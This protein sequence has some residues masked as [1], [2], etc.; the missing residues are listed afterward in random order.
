MPPKIDLAGKRFGRLVVIKEVDPYYP[1]NSNKRHRKWLCKCDC[2]NY[3][4]TYQGGLLRG[5]TKSCSCLRKENIKQHTNKYSTNHPLYKVLLSMRQRCSNPKA[6][7]Y[8]HYGGKGIK[9]CDEW[10]KIPGGYDAFYEWAMSNGYKKG[11]S[12][13][14]I[15]NNGNYEPANCRWATYKEQANNTSQNHFLTYDGK[16]LTIAQWAEKTGINYET[17]SARVRNGWNIEEII[18]AIPRKPKGKLLRFNGELKTVKEWSSITGIPTG[19]IY[20]RL[21][22]GWPVDK[23]LGTESDKRYSTRRKQK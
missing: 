1:P 19:T 4:K 16:T 9:V 7:E 18:G 3:I 21:N 22:K 14:R 6:I 5:E 15:D 2:G 10:N 11:L 20:T 12:I 23:T 8:K 13:D 17:I